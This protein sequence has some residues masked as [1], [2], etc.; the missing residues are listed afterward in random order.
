MLKLKSNHQKHRNRLFE[1][2]GRRNEKNNT[3]QE[4]KGETMMPRKNWIHGM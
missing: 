4:K 1:F 2:G 3:K